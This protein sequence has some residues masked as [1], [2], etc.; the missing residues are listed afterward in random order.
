MIFE[1]DQVDALV[2]HVSEQSRAAVHRGVLSAGM[3]LV[4]DIKG[5]L[6]SREDP[7]PI[8][9]KT[10]ANAWQC[11]ETPEGADVYNDAPHA[12]IIE[13]GG[14]GSD[15]G[16]TWSVGARMIEALSEW[17]VRKGLVGQGPGGHQERALEDE[18][19][20]MAWA[21]AKSMQKHG[22]FNQGPAHPGADEGGGLRITE[23]AAATLPKILAEEIAAELREAL[24]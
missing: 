22:M 15:A 16:G 17:V 9:Q 13:Y 18:A 20:S 8:D 11:V 1:I 21:I 5:V 3:R 6:I 23:K 10:Y 12:P 7:P 4:R 24:G 19:Q 2:R 14:R